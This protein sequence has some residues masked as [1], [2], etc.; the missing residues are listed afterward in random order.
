[1]A[2][3][4]FRSE[5]SARGFAKKLE[6]EVAHDFR[7]VKAG[8]GRYEVG[9]DFSSKPER[10]SVLDAIKAFTGYSPTTLEKGS[11]L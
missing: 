6:Q 2:W 1:M 3:S 11:G 8:P 7:V 9:F 4:P 10:S 5:T